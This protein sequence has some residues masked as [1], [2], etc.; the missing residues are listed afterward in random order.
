MSTLDGGVKTSTLDDGVKNVETFPDEEVV[1]LVRYG[2]TESEQDKSRW[3][4]RKQAD[5]AERI[6][7]DNEK[8]IDKDYN[9]WSATADMQY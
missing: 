3:E 2:A 9:P 1:K 6:R 5:F 7:M 8:N 4:L